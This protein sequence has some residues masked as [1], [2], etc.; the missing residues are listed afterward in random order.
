MN[1]RVNRALKP[2]AQAFDEVRIRT[3]PR[4]KESGLSG[5][6]WRISAT[7]EFWR[8][9]KPPAVENDGQRSLMQACT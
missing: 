3:V 5:D 9:G 1:E 4:W 7:V 6:E 2:D 8:K